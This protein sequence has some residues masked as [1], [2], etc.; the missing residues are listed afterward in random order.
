MLKATKS[1]CWL[2]LAVLLVLSV[3]SLHA[4]ESNSTNAPGF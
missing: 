3:V 2:G 1:A 4:Q